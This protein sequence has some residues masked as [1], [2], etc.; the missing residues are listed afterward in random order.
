MIS[1]IIQTYKLAKRLNADAYVLSIAMP[2][3][4]TEFWRIVE[5][6]IKPEELDRLNWNGQ[7]AE[8]TNKCNKS[9]VPAE[10]LVPMYN[11]IYRALKKQ[12]ELKK[13]KR[14][15][16]Y[17]LTLLKMKGRVERCKFELLVWVRRI[18]TFLHIRKQVKYL[19]GLIN[20]R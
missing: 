7:D 16:I 18:I 14:Y 12:A 5:P 17:L 13:I 20:A 19:R 9:A 10:I 2:L 3:P 6:D 8:F 15:P 1:F 11:S 4:N